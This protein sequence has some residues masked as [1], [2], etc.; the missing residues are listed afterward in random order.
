V[1]LPTP[2]PSRRTIAVLVLLSATLITLDLRGNA[3]IDSGRA[4]VTEL[5]APVSGFFR[6]V[7][8]PAVNAWNGM[9]RYDDLE[10]ENAQLR[11]KIEAQEGAAIAAEAKSQL[12]DELRAVSGLDILS[13]YP[14]LTASVVG[15]PASNLQLSIEIDRGS[16]DGLEPGMPVVTAG[17]LVGRLGQVTP[18]HSFVRMLY[19][20]Q[21]GV[22]V[23]IV[24]TKKVIAPATTTTTVAATET[25]AAT[26]TV[27]ATETG[28]ST[29]DAGAAVSTAAS[30]TTTTLPP[31]AVL[32]TGLLRGQGFDRPL[33]VDLVGAGETIEVGDAVTTFASSGSLFPD[34]I[35]VGRVKSVRTRPGSAYLDVL[36][37]PLVDLQRISFVRVIKY[38]PATGG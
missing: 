4:T 1:A 16:R 28:E 34:D 29:G 7:T 37:E 9:L 32:D 26:E 13:N 17:G 33:T 11:D 27:A 6:F 12:Y 24:G 8:K 10:R 35:P 31:K 30:S 38:T 15:E 5:T 3:I 14:Y 21:I 18:T 2:G 22:P 20:P 36:V 19:D 25:D 23:K